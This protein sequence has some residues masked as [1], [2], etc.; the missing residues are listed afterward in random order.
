MASGAMTAQADITIETVAVGNPG[1]A[2]DTSTYGAVAYSY[3]I[4][5]YEVTNSHY[6]AFLTA[7][8]ATDTFSLYNTNMGSN[9]VGGITQAGSSGSYTYAVK[10]G[11]AN[12]PVS[13]VSFWD[14]TRF[15]NW[16]SNSQGS[17]DTETGSYALTSGGISANSIARNVGAT[18][19]VASENEWYKAAYYDP[20]KGGPSVGGYWLYP[21]KAGSISTE[22]ANYGN[23][24]RTLTDVG[25][26]SSASSAYGTYDQG[27]NLWERNEQIMGGSS[28]GLR[29]GA[30]D[31]GQ[32]QL[33]P[34]VRGANDPESELNV[35]GFRVVSLAPIPEPSIYGAAMGVMALGVVMMRRRKARGSF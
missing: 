3:D 8:A 19:V 22:D 2:A 27:G 28:R 25:I 30:W 33:E 15:T 7:K 32:S 23:V 13:F 18:W 1:N 17:G 24:I 12:K 4:G 10:S 31:T 16:L 26:Y 14:A 35:I 34:A 20:N 21:T 9:A 5:K 6:A 11:F 29:G